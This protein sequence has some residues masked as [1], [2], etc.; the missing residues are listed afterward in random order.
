MD[1]L[2]LI[3]RLKADA[4]EEKNKFEKIR[5][6][7]LIEVSNFH[8]DTV[9]SEEFKDKFFKLIE[10]CT[11][12]LMKGNDNFFAAFLI[13]MKR[14]INLGLQTA[15]ATKAAGTYF[16]IYFN[17]CI[18]LEC[19]MPQMEALI[20]HEIYHVMSL[21]YM[22]AKAIKN[23][24]STLAINIAM[25]IS[26]NQYIINLPN[27]SEKI[28]NVRKA[29]NVNLDEE[30]TME[31]YADKIQKALD[32]LKKEKGNIDSYNDNI[33]NKSPIG[34]SHNINKAHDLWY[35]GN[36]DLDDKA[37]KEIVKKIASNAASGKIPDS[38][39]KLIGSLNGEAEIGWKDY[40]RRSLGTLS[41][42]YKKTITRK[43]RRQPDRLDIRGRLSKHIAEIIVAI[44]ISGSMSN[45]EIEQIMIEIFS[46]VKNYPS[47]I[48]ILECDSEVRRAYKVK[49][50]KQIKKKLDTKGGTKYT[51]VFEY[52]N[53]KNLRNSM[54]IYFTDG[55]GEKDLGILPI[56]KRT[57][58]VLT[59]KGEEL[60]LN[61]PYGVIKKLSKVKVQEPD[62]DYAKNEI[63]EM[64]M[65]EWAK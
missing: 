2:K 5:N 61:N 18:F 53:R 54:L 62:L 29:L 46:M 34:S 1:I 39:E 10:L 45:K 20:K 23:K 40:L 37:V 28:E 59:G 32:R 8:K 63:K 50:Q 26:I 27:W 4:M 30:L 49:N 11:L 57:I 15:A 7:L 42:G 16:T 51:P 38:I 41:S 58:W 36:N 24:Y 52:I 12:S 35:M 55:V 19:T 25:D 44:D 47:E 33:D 31:E 56:H 22:R 6:E 43:D 60:S 64:R 3:V 9:V 21:H 14:D 65:L 48:T 13:Q 17:P